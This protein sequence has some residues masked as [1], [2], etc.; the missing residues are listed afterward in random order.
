MG[1]HTDLGVDEDISPTDL[2]R[3]YHKLLLKVHP[4]QGGDRKDYKRVHHAYQMITDPGYVTEYELEH[5]PIYID[6]YVKFEHYFF[7]K[8]GLKTRIKERGYEENS[9]GE[10]V[11][12]IAYVK[13]D[14]EPKM[15]FPFQ[16]TYTR[17]EFGDGV[18]HDVYVMYKVAEHDKF[19]VTPK[20]LVINYELDA[21][22]AIKGGIAQIETPVGLKGLYVPPGTNAEYEFRIGKD[23]KLGDVIVKIT[24]I[25]VPT[26][27]NL[28]KNE[29]YKEFDIDWEQN[30]DWDF[31][32]QHEVDK[33][34]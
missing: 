14:I 13:Q 7:G 32:D 23:N 16:K 26:P 29:N 15:I 22:I 11:A 27:E 25:R 1:Y 30:D 4:D 3:A 31:L 10:V 34:I 18:F 2:K 6:V 28:K 8:K 17:I 20:G 9:E 24:K 19:N 21:H 12:N 5:E 33:L